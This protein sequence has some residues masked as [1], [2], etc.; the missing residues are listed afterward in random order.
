MVKGLSP[1][2]VASGLKRINGLAAP[3]WTM[4]SLQTPPSQVLRSHYQ[5]RNFKST[6]EFLNKV[7]SI[8]HLNRHHP[9]IT[10]TY[11][12][13]DLELTTHDA[14]NSITEKDIDVAEAISTE[15]IKFTTSR[16]A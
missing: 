13:V 1:A 11:N 16:W 5:F 15:Y 9:T 3:R 8:A 12:K 14:G 4:Q 2:E 10:T 7:A 6:W